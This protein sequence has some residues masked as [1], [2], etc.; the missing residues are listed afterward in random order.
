MRAFSNRCAKMTTLIDRTRSIVEYIQFAKEMNL[1]Y[2]GPASLV[3]IVEWLDSIRKRGDSAPQQ[4]LHALTVYNETLELGWNLE[5]P[6]IKTAKRDN[7]KRLRKQAPAVPLEF[8]IAVE[9]AAT[10]ASQ[11]TGVRLF[12]SCYLLTVLASLR[13]ADTVEIDAMFKTDT[14][15]AGRSIDQKN[16]R[17]GNIVWATPR[18]GIYS[19]GAWLNPLWKYWEKVQP[20][21]DGK[22]RYLF[23]HFS[24]NW[25]IDYNRKGSHGVIQATLTRLEL[26]LGFPK[27]LKLHSARTWFATCARQ[28]MF[29]LEDRTTL[30]HWKEGSKMPNL[31]DRAVCATELNLRNQILQKLHSGWTPTHAFEIPNE[32]TATQETKKVLAESSAD[33][34]SVTSTASFAKK[35]VD[36]SKLEED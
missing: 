29:G 16:P 13:F 31:Y 1:P 18:V 28:L 3:T 35:E 5:H 32:G 2:V 6:A 9:K 30:G 21:K 23:P 11:K 14:V 27:L 33:T 36:I 15:L 34:T 24:P 8:I 7:K 26:L 12:C 19:N 20:K 25:D 4:G 22:Y 10:E 17:G